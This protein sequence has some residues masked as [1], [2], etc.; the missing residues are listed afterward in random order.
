MQVAKWGNSLAVR[1][2]ADVAR[3][4]NLKIGDEVELTAL[5]DKQLAIVT[6]QQRRDAALARIHAM[7]R[8]L[9]PGYSFDRDEANAR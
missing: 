4:L 1:I 2:P 5:D 9:P 7:A 3:V 6:E 8:P